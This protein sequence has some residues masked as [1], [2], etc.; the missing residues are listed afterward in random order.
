MKKLLLT[1]S[2]LLA[3]AGSAQA[4]L[5]APQLLTPQN[6]ANLPLKKAV[7]FTWQK[8]TGAK[9]WIVFSS[10]N[11]FA[12]YDANKFKCLDA[13]TCSA[14]NVASESYNLVATHAILK[15]NGNYFW[16]VQAVNAKDKSQTGEI[17]PFSVG[18][19]SAS[20]TTNVAT[21]YTKIANDG[22]ALPETAVLGSNPKDW[23][24]TKDN[25]TGLTWEIKTT[26]K[27]LRDMNKTYTNYTVDYPKCDW[28]KCE[29]KYKGKY[30]DNTN[31]DGFV[32]AVNKQKLCGSSEWRLP[33][34]TELTG[35]VYCSDGKYTKTLSADG[36]SICTGSPVEPFINT[37]YF[38]N[39]Q[40]I[41]WSA[42]SVVDDSSSASGVGIDS[43]SY[44]PSAKFE[45]Y[46]VRL[47]RK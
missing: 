46:F 9:Y 10:D 23:A 41:Y 43:N 38:Q 17:R 12:N 18:A 34:Q 25:K 32:T 40:D 27:G 37:T 35:L 11:S 21:P 29:T 16:Q 5:A 20:G 24:C 15:T 19:T 36:G 30:G 8:V 6:A 1:T 33:T 47:V 31:A 13:K 44:S 7:K 2:L 14:F 4:D 22:S 3:F 42:S 28:T 26:D 39:N 45:D